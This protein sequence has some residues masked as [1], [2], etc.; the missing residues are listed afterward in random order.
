MYLDKKDLF[1]QS[2]MRKGLQV[3][4]VDGFTYGYDVKNDCLVYEKWVNGSWRYAV[5]VSIDI[6]EFY[7]D[8]EYSFNC[9]VNEEFSEAYVKHIN[10]K[11][12]RTSDR[13]AGYMARNS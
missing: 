4:D 6:I 2:V 13:K 8:A 11:L 3:Y 5:L 9:A 12:K 10:R 7:Q 1:Y